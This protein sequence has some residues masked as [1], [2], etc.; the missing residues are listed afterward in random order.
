[1]TDILHDELQAEWTNAQLG[2]VF[3]INKGIAHRIGSKEMRDFEAHIVHPYLLSANQ[4]GHA[5]D[6]IGTSFAQHRPVS[7]KQ[8]R[9]SVQKRF[10]VVASGGWLCILFVVMLIDSIM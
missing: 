10:N 6:Y 2:Y 4:E 9:A 8:I 3:G 1:L 7:P 5:I